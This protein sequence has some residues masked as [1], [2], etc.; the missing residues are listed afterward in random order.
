MLIYFINPCDPSVSLRK[1]QRSIWDKYFIWQPLGL[2]ILASLTPKEWSIRVIDEN[3]HIPNYEAL[4]RP[5]LVGIGA[6]TCQADRAYRIARMFRLR[7]VPVILGGI[8]ATM[9]SSEALEYV[10]AVVIG[11]A[12]NVWHHVLKDVK[13]HCIKR[14]Y[15]GERPEMSHVPF[16]RHDLMS[17]NYPFGSIQ[18]ARGC[19]FRCK[20]CS[21]TSFYGG[22]YRRRPVKN[23]IE[24]LKLI[25]QKYILITDDNLIGVSK[26]DAEGIK[27]IFKIMIRE[28]INKK[29]IAQATMNIAD[30]VELLELA[31][32]AGCVSILIGFESI[33]SEGLAEIN[34]AHFHTEGHDIR[35][36]VQ[37]MQEHGI[38]VAG[39]FIIG[40][41][42][43]DHGIGKRIAE[44]AHSYGLD[45]IDVL[46]L[47]PLPGTE[48]WD[49]MKSENRIRANSFPDDWKYYT[50]QFPVLNYKHF[51]PAE[52][53]H[54]IRQCTRTYYSCKPMLRRVFRNFITMRKPF[55]TLLVNLSKRMHT[56]RIDRTLYR[57]Y[58]N[59]SESSLA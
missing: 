40:L 37:R 11:E 24:E 10:D 12:E 34:K 6:F 8:H 39:S 16:A 35:S 57:E 13:D 14:V 26:S 7:N 28:R 2:M 46:L 50:L 9:C 21:V 52:I 51:T 27:E 23:I 55:S 45:A 3:L 56:S 36:A 41:D 42:A 31:S 29:W 5:D 30:D 17:K 44:I 20:F 32:R 4:A 1:L 22:T 33:C 48:I 19:P 54:E 49:R 38:L 53:V 47:T 59:H 58:S 43:D 18:F 15:I 25:P